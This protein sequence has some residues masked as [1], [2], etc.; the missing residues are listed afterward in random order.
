LIWSSERR[1]IEID[2]ALAGLSFHDGETVELKITHGS[3]PLIFSHSWTM[4]VAN[5]KTP[6]APPQITTALG[7][8]RVSTFETGTDGWRRLGGQQGATLWRDKSTAAAGSASL[9]L[10]H[11]QLAGPF[12][13]TIRDTP[14][15]ARRFPI[16]TF[17]YC[18]PPSAKASL[19]CE[20]DG[21]MYEIAF[22]DD[23]HT[24]PVIGTI[25]SVQKDD[26]WHEAELDLLGAAQRANAGSTIITKLFFAD[27]GITNTIQDVAWHVDDFRFVPALPVGEPSTLRWSANDLS[28]IAGYSVVVDNAPQTVPDEVF[29]A[30]TSAPVA[31]SATYLHVRAKDNAGNWGAPS[32]FR[33]V[34]LAAPDVSTPVTVEAAIPANKV[35]GEPALEVKI[36]NAAQLD[37]ES[38]RWRMR[39]GEQTREYSLSD[40]GEDNE[41]IAFDPETGVL[42]WCD[43]S[44]TARH[45]FKPYDLTLELMA[46]DLAGKAAINRK[47]QLRIE[48][49]LD[50][51][52][53]S[54]PFVS[55]IPADRLGRYDFENGDNGDTGIRRSAWVFSDASTSATGRKSAR[56]VNLLMG[57]FFSAF[58]KKHPY[59]VSRYPRLEFDYRFEIPNETMKTRQWRRR[60]NAS[61]APAEHSPYNLNL[62]AIVNGD[63]QIV[64]FIGG[65]DASLAFRENRIGE[66]EDAKADDQWHHASIDFGA[67]LRKR[68]PHAP[69]FFAEYVGTWSTGPHGYENPQGA[70]LWLD[71]I[72]FFSSR[73]SST[74]FEWRA[75]EDE[76]GIS[77]YSFVLDQKPGT[78]PQEKVLTTQ[79]HREFK[80][81]KPGTWYF[82]LRARD[83]AGN[84]SA[85]SHVK[86]ELTTS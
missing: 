23:D 2:P 19:I 32:H 27:A 49:S 55:Y 16:L 73:G 77:G 26:K 45:N 11:R 42:R 18:V 28:G 58:F 75:P 12:G 65:P 15:D 21:N 62:V 70:S 44:L 6:P 33:F 17:S 7:P 5:D 1:E 79:T 4:R 63:M 36:S 64:K 9:R 54:A 47:W 34:P 51:T 39:S 31:A 3:T 40:E 71:N 30:G 25:G 37:V 52:A 57:D 14:F 78:L 83:G 69:R 8:D 66:I 43:P 38:V 72:T 82:H 68:Y 50:K 22:T 60:R 10:Y 86:F 24:F 74:S 53:P 35:L 59:S 56:V 85:A 41:K 20:I 29:D 48:P 81:L 13:A 61:T 84:W 46:S 67:M 76:N 80:D